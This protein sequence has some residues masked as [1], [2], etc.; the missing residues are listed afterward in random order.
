MGRVIMARAPVRN[1]PSAINFVNKVI[2]YETATPA[3]DYTNR[4]LYVAEV[5]FPSPW[6]PGD[7]ITLDGSQYSEA[8]IEHVIEPCTDMEN[9]RMYETDHIHPYDIHLTRLALIDELNTG[10]YGQV[11]QFGHGHFF[12][13]S[14]GDAN[15]TV[16]DADG[17]TNGPNYFLIFALNCASGAF[18]VSCLMEAFVENPD[19]GSVMSVGAAREAFPSNTFNYQ[20]TFYDFMACQSRGR[21]VDAF[22]AARLQLIGNT[23]RNT[24]D[25]W[26]QM[27]AAFIGDPA[28]TIWNGTPRA[29]QISAPGSLDVGEQ[30]LVIQVSD[31]GGPVKKDA[32]SGVCDPTC[33]S[34]SGAVCCTTCGCSGAVKCQPV[35]EAPAKWDCETRCCFDYTK[36]SCV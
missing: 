13:M 32:A 22:N 14:V 8:L 17:L 36:K 16:S 21:A 9:V 26:T 24:V 11:N 7:P 1:L 10:E 3:D 28:T 35:C 33:M 6:N 19:G 31:A 25:R 30:Q 5:L 27:N 18:D 20:L 12:N 29:P 34:Q 15:F 4:I 23:D 2:T